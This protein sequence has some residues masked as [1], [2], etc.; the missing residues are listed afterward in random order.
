MRITVERKNRER[1]KRD[2]GRFPTR[3]ESCSEHI[4]DPKFRRMETVVEQG[5]SGGFSEHY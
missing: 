1:E 5:P 3:Q 2:R 4:L